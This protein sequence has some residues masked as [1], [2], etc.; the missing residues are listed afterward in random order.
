[1]KW[2]KKGLIY[3]VSKFND[4][5]YSHTHKPKP[6]LINENILRI[7]FGIRDKQSRTRTTFIDVDPNDLKKIIYEHPKPVLDLGPIGAFDDSGANVSCVL[8][9]G[10]DIYMYYIG[11]NPSTTV[12]TRNSIGLVISHDKGITFKRQW[13]GPIL[14]R[15]MEEPFYTGA[16]FVM[17]EGEI[18]KMWYTSGTEWKEISNKLEICYRIKYVE[19][20][21]GIHWN[22]KN[23]SCINPKHDLEAIASPAVIKVNRI[24]KMWYCYRN[25]DNF[26]NDKEK[27]YK[28]GYAESKD[29]IKWN[30]LDQEMDLKPS[31]YGWDSKMVAYPAVFELKGTLYMIY[32]GNDFGA[33]GF[34]YAVLEK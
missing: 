4:L 12:H 8:K 27:G 17:K 6:L 10:S 9:N 19:S 20:S 23:V 3:S 15:N 32:N 22:R 18:W 34:G 11:W 14:D 26:R 31:N 28:I 1:M 33:S 16:V 13:Y 7:Y 29:G 24:Y 21:D 25:I 5:A 30:R 2:I